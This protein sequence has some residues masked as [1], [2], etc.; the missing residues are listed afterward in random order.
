MVIVNLLLA[1]K[2]EYV[3]WRQ[4]L[5]QQYMCFVITW[6]TV[7]C[8]SRQILKSF[9]NE[10]KSGNQQEMNIVLLKFITI[11]QIIKH[12]KIMTKFIVI[13]QYW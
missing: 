7:K 3:G 5:L 12:T 1:K 13:W 2:V 8:A 11:L 4:V 10:M 6:L 9:G